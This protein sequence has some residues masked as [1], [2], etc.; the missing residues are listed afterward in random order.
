MYSLNFSILLQL[1]SSSRLSIN[2]DIIGFYPY[3]VYGN[4]SVDGTDVDLLNL[5]KKVTGVDVKLNFAKTY[6]G[7]V[8]RVSEHHCFAPFC[9]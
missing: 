7:V 3:I 5:W 6:D 9:I 2:A 4:N 8:Q 1:C